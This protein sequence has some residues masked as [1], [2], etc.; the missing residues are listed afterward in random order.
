MTEPTPEFTYD[1]LWGEI[2]R[3]SSVEVRK[4]GDVDK[5]EVMAKKWI[6]SSAALALMKKV[7]KHPKVRML[8][9][10]DQETK[11]YLWVLRRDAE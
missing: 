6:G 8:K 3:L 1:E 10:L 7:A 5:E 9:V 11:R 4:P 2:D